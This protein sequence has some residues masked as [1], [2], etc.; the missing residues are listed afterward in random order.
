MVT[1]A[2][3][4]FFLSLIFLGWKFASVQSSP[5]SLTSIFLLCDETP[6]AKAN[7]SHRWQVQ[8]SPFSTQ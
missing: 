4:H 7:M 5:Y 6:A 2:H 3:V 8:T 1:T